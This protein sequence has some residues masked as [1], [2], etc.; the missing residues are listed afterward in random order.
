MSAGYPSATLVAGSLRAVVYLPGGAEAYYRASRF[1]HATMVGDITFEGVKLFGSNFWRAPHDPEWTENGVGLASEWGCGVDGHVCGPGWDAT[2]SIG[3]SNGVLGYAAAKVGEPFLKIGV[4]LLI[5]GS[6]LA[7]GPAGS[8]DTYKFN[9]PYRFYQPA[10][11]S[12]HTDAS[13]VTM[14]HSASLGA[15]AY[16]L[17]RTVRVATDATLRVETTLHNTG[18]AAFRTPYYSHNLLNIN[19]ASPTGPGVRLALDVD[20]SSFSDSPPWAEPIEGYFELATDPQTALP[21]LREAL[22]AT[23]AVVAPTKIKAVYHGS[24]ARSNGTYQV[25]FDRE[26]LAMRSDLTGPA[27]LYAYNLYVEER[28]MSPEPIQMVALEPGETTT[29]THT[30]HF[31][32]YEA[33]GRPTALLRS[34]S[35]A[36][37]SCRWRAAQMHRGFVE[38]HAC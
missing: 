31:Q 24:A 3:S 19:G 1:D 34:R 32:R 18:S 12:V 2:S 22:W 15:Y 4:G 8:G 23:R 28:T 20:L 14:A 29:L 6:C 30:L 26:G 33:A 21:P 5:K 17:N 27:P 25:A 37:A 13:Y 16:L 9:S 35:A 36:Q 11:W 10:R 7:C 38:M